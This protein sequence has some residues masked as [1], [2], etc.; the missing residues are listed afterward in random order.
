MNTFS[1]FQLPPAIFLTQHTFYQENSEK[2]ALDFSASLGEDFLRG[3]FELG[4]FDEHFALDLM[5]RGE[6][7]FLKLFKMAIEEKS[8]KSWK[9]IF[10]RCFFHFY[11][12]SPVIIKCVSKMRYVKL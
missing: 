7:L 11:L 2:I 9:V 3:L 6:I 8:A 12:K 1:N 10:S 5:E 4:L